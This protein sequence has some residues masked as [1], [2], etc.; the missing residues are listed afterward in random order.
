MIFTRKYLTGKGVARMSAE[1]KRC[2]DCGKYKD[3][4]TQFFYNGGD[5]VCGDWE[6]PYAEKRKKEIEG[7]NRMEENYE[8]KTDSV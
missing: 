4:M 6:L 8:R 3:C 1:N 2:A 5:M 7:W